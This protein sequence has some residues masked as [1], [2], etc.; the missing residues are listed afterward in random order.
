MTAA[1]GLAEKR[2]GHRRSLTSVTREQVDAAL[3]VIRAVPVGTR[4]TVNDIR[5]HLDALEFPTRSRGALFGIALAEG[6]IVALYLS[7]G[8]GGEAPMTVSST[9]RSAHRASVQVYQR[10]DVT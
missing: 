8:G 3:D 6:L 9:G 2:L 4:V 1:V 5:P 10:T 7:T